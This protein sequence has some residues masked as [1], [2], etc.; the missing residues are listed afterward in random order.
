MPNTR[1]PGFSNHHLLNNLLHNYCCCRRNIAFAHSEAIT[2]LVPHGSCHGPAQTVYMG[3]VSL[4]SWKLQTWLE[5]HCLDEQHISRLSDKLSHFPPAPSLQGHLPRRKKVYFYIH[6]H[7][8]DKLKFSVNWYAGYQSYR[9]VYKTDTFLFSYSPQFWEGNIRL[10][11]LEKPYSSSHK[12]KQET[13]WYMKYKQLSV[14]VFCLI[15]FY[16]HMRCCC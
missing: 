13:I 9:E 6:I 3:S 11:F 16:L 8:W 12:W 1:V 2:S 10:P 5:S 4:F 15:K 7:K 14:W